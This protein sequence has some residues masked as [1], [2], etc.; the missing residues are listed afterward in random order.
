VSYWLRL[1]RETK[2]KNE[3]ADVK[4]LRPTLDIGSHIN[5]T[6]QALPIAEATQERRLSA[7]ACRPII[8]RQSCFQC[9]CAHLRGSCQGKQEHAPADDE[10]TGR[11]LRGLLTYPRIRRGACVRQRIRRGCRC[12]GSLSRLRRPQ[13]RLSLGTPVP[14]LGRA[15]MKQEAHEALAALVGLDWAD[16]KHEVC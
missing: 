13:A 15:P 12:L 16:A 1:F 10:Y 7:V 14:P 3:D 9:S 2:G 4:K 8:G 11:S 5:A 6:L